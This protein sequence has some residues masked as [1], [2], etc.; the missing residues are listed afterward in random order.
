MVLTV[1]A[2][3]ARA[4]AEPGRTPL[5]SSPG[6]TAGMTTASA[7][8]GDADA[9]ADG[10]ERFGDHRDVV[11]RRVAGEGP[12]PEPPTPAA[13]PFAAVGEEQREP[14]RRRD[15]EVDP[16]DAVGRRPRPGRRRAR[17]A[18]GPP[19]AGER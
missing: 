9:S 8:D 17:A 11:G 4:V 1:P 12:G 5:R 18:A 2:A 13:E 14:P 15:A 16:G 19:S 10:A 7:T 3:A 6:T